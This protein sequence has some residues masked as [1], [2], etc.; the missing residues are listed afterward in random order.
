MR[1]TWPVIGEEE[2]DAAMSQRVQESRRAVRRSKIMAFG[3]NGWGVSGC[4]GGMVMG[5]LI[6]ECES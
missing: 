2:E 4:G 6:V 3:L 1:Q 5:L